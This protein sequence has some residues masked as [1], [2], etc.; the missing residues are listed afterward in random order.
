LST[1]K[2]KMKMTNLNSNNILSPYSWILL[3]K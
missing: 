2:K 3:K 1:N